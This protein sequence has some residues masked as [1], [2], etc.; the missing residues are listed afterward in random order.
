MSTLVT[1]VHVI[2]CLFL[3]LTVLLQQGK[4]GMGGAFGGSN[5]GSVFGGGGAST[6]LR[7]LTSAAA[8]IFMLTSMTLA[9]L[10]TQDAGDALEKI[11]QSEAAKKRREKE[12]QKKL[13]EAAGDAGMSSIDLSGDGG[14]PLPITIEPTDPG[15]GS[16][17]G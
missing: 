5:A 6:F 14:M 4:G 16:A 15:A 9:W 8:I 10:A 3:M 13:L 17:S 12:S 11:S 2:V 1:I 7:R